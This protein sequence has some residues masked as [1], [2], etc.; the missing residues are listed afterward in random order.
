MKNLDFLHKD[1]FSIDEYKNMVKS[2][3]DKKH[4]LGWFDNIYESANGDYTKV[5]W[6]DLEP[7]P[8]L[9]DWLNKNYVKIK[10]KKACVIGCGVGDD[11]QALNDFGFKVTAF[12]ISPTA[13][14]L[15]KNR[16]PNSK[17]NFVVA[18][19]FNYPNEWFENF[20]VVYEC[21]TIQVLPDDYRKKARERMSSLI[22]KNGY[23]LVSCR[24]RKENEKLD[25]IPKPL[26][27]SEIDE[28]QTINN[29]EQQSFL[30]YDDNQE[31][32]VPHFFAVYKKC[33]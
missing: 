7:S 28:F 18:D 16:Y 25:E 22:S 29:L 32:R 8:Y 15:C 19:L 9:I 30:A 2:Y 24:S 3:Q 27:K 11:A 31:P 33:R 21:N 12:D 13:I 6:A 5:F 20:D 14:E 10:N 1:S 17:V 26:T 23:I 4:P